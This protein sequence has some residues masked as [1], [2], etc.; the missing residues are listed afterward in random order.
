MVKN[1]FG[2]SNI[3]SADRSPATLG[4][5]VKRFLPRSHRL[6]QGF[7]EAISLHVQPVGQELSRAWIIC[8]LTNL[9]QTEEELRAFQDRIFL[10]DRPILEQQVPKRLP[11]AAGAEVPMACDRLSQAYRRLLS[12]RGLRY[13]VM[14]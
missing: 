13:G 7:H 8:A 9:G 3:A 10:Q 11:L 1:S 14:P 12:E 5:F 2:F 6:N 4:R